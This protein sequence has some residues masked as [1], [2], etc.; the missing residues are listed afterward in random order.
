MEMKSINNAKLGLFVIAGI[1]FLV[2]TLYM[3]GRNRNILGSTFTVAVNMENVNGLLPGN[4]VRFR[5]IDVG[6]V[7]SIDIVD[8]TSIYVTLTI[9]KKFKHY[10]RRNAMASIGTDGLMGNKLMNINP[11][12]G[13]SEPVE[14][15]SVLSA[16][17][18]VETDE[19]LRTLN[20]TNNN[21]AVITRNLQQITDKLNRNNS[22]WSLLGDTMIAVDLKNAVKDIRIAGNRTA[23][24]TGEAAELVHEIRSGEGLAGALLTDTTLKEQLVKS[25]NQIKSGSAD[26]SMLITNM[27]SLID[28]IHN[29]NGTAGHVI[30]D[31]ILRNRLLKTIVNA[32]EGT[33]RFSEN[34][35]A[36]KHNFLFR[37]YFTRQ[38]KRKKK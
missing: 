28:D 23:E 12:A 10:I 5:G 21:I 37:R 15:G 4:N 7:K 16:T 6:T 30:G 9:K 2:L 11:R 13:H 18:P 31:T 26:L 38:E 35:E 34:M 25:L 14:G 3:I 29:G 33:S 17:P 1:L 8:D 32:E 27:N 19:M 24:F 22:L 20:T 36:L